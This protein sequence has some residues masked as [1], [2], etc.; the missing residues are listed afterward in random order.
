MIQETKICVFSLSERDVFKH[1]DMKF[2]INWLKNKG[3]NPYLFR[4]MKPADGLASGSIVLFSFDARIFGQATVKKDVEKLSLEEKRQYGDDYNHKMIL[5]PSV[6]IFR[7]H[8]KKRDVSLK[9]G[10]KFGQVFT[11]LDRKQY[12]QILEIA[13]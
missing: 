9:I 1:K 7:N 3:E 5:D 11:Y 2:A 4:K 8:P 10:K 13:R 12:Q 6:E